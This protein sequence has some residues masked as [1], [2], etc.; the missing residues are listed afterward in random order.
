MKHSDTLA[1]IAP[2]LVA[3][4][5]EFKAV[6]KDR[7]NPHFKNTYATLDNI[8]ETTRP[9]LAKHSLSVVQ[10]A[11]TP[12]TDTDGE[13]VA[14]TVESVLV[15]ASGE[16]ISESV[17]MPLAKL[18]PQGAGSAVTYGRRYSLCALLALATGE[19]DDG[20]AATT[21]T[22][23]AQPT[24]QRAIPA[25]KPA[26][27]QDA[28]EVFDAEPVG[29]DAP[30]CPICGGEMWDDR[31]SKTNPK[32][33]DFK[34]KNK[35]KTRGGPGCAGVIWPPKRAAKPAGRKL[36]PVA[37]GTGEFDDFPPPLEDLDSDDLGY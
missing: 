33:P 35:P 37:A 13:L 22:R 4:Q 23:A 28:A 30:S 15:H 16:W 25:Q 29:G 32:A 18:D 11:S 17:V 19:D 20:E 36:Q 34:C 8:I 5:A 7:T 3:A 21:Q 24:A 27:Q 31:A 10:G 2:A 9:V 6:G 12:T 26:T 14:V 1:K